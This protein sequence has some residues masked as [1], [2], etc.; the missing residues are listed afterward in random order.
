MLTGQQTYLDLGCAF[1]Q[2]IRLLVADGVASEQCY[3][4]DLR[5]DFLELGYDLFCDRET[6]KTKFIEGDV[7]NADSELRDLE[8]EVDI[9]DASS[10]FHLFSW[11]QQ[12][13]VARRVVKLLRPRRDSLLVGRQVGSTLPGE[14]VRRDGNGTRYRHNIESWRRMWTEVGEETGVQVKVD[15]RMSEMPDAIKTALGGSKEDWRP[16][17]ERGMRMEFSVRRVSGL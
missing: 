3:G 4:S 17:D 2:D 13:L 15:G 9:I 12:K 7:F 8:G 14:Y 6:L 1:G 16:E 5:L 11:D 10:F